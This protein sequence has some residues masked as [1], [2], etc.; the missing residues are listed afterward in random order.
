MCFDRIGKMKKATKNILVYKALGGEGKRLYSPYHVWHGWTMREERKEKDFVKNATQSS[1]VHGYHSCKTPL[2][3]SFHA[4]NV[5]RFTI[6]KGA[7]YYEN[8]DEYLS[9]KIYLR[10]YIPVNL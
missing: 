6:P 4:D 8:N 9:N 5:Y 2:D 1:L 7:W 3:A 10:S